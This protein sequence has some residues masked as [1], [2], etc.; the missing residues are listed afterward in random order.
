[1]LGRAPAKAIVRGRLTAADFIKLGGAATGAP[2]L[3]MST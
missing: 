3:R 2:A 1:M